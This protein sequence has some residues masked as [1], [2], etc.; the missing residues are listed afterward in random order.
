MKIEFGQTQRQGTERRGRRGDSGRMWKAVL[1]GNPEIVIF[2]PRHN[3]GEVI[4]IFFNPLA[5][6]ADLTLKKKFNFV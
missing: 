3:I 2:D 1:T 5:K 4:Q 6:R